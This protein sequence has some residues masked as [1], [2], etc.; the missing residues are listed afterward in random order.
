MNV[1]IKTTS[2][3]DLICKN[4]TSASIQWK[5]VQKPE[6]MTSEEFD[7]K[8]LLYKEDISAITFHG[9]RVFFL[10]GNDIEYIIISKS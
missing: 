6:N 7:E 4:F 8:F 2:G 10:D 9:D 3:D 1:L 5:N